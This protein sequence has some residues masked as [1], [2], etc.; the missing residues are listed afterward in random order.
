[1]TTIPPDWHYILGER[2]LVLVDGAGNRI[3]EPPPDPELEDIKARAAKLGYMV[4]LKNEYSGT[5]TGRPADAQYGRP[6]SFSSRRVSMTCPLCGEATHALIIP[7]SHYVNTNDLTG[8]YNLQE[9]TG[10]W[11]CGNYKSCAKCF[12]DADL[13]N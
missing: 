4:K 8:M 6:T 12:T 7:E 11:K 13:E 3:P 1:M 5:A 9:T 10:F 2:G